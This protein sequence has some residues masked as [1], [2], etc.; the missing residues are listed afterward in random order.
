MSYTLE[1]VLEVILLSTYLV[2]LDVDLTQASGRHLVRNALAIGSETY[3]RARE[4][5]I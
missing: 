4:I 2:E 5:Q 3:G 1:P